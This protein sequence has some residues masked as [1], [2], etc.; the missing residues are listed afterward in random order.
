MKMFIRLMVPLVFLGM[1]LFL[2]EQILQKS[3]SFRLLNSRLTIDTLIAPCP[4]GNLVLDIDRDGRDEIIFNIDSQA[5]NKRDLWLLDIPSAGRIEKE[6]PQKKIVTIP[7]SHLL[8]DA[9]WEEKTNRGVFKCLGLEKGDL[10]LYELYLPGH[11]WKSHK[12]D[13]LQYR[14]LS[15]LSSFT[16]PYLVDLEGDGRQEMIIIFQSYYIHYPRGVVCFDA[17]SRK[18][19]WQYYGGA[20]FKD[21]AFSDLDGDNRKEVI[22]SSAAVNNGAVNNS[23]DDS[24]S[25]V[26]VLDRTG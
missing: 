1:N 8:F 17:I 2:G 10:V 4:P 22:L 14:M 7:H 21:V 19:K 11:E 12:F 5:M 20:L 13:S 3:D 9:R 16:S 24:H 6:I 18:C 15:V 25:Y 23:T 26:I